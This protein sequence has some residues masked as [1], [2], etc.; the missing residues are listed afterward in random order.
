ML[1]DNVVAITGGAGLIGKSFSKAVIESGGKVIIGDISVEKGRELQEELG[2]KNVVFIEVDSSNV[3]SVD[4]FLKLGKENFGKIDS[5]IHCAY[6]RS[7]QW[8]TKF[9]DLEE[10]SLKQ[11]LFHQLGGAILFSQR[12]VSFYKKQ[13]YGNLIHISSIQGV[14][15]PKFEHYVHT[16]MVSPI[17]YSAIKSGIISITRYLAKYCKGQNIRVN[18]ISPGGILDNQPKIFLEKYNS[19]CASKG[20]MNPEDLNGTI[21]YLLSSYSQ[22]VNG[23]NIIIDDGWVL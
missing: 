5:A 4:N 12:L 6:P 22:Y 3:N 16:S 15:A 19:T 10:N 7:D 20:M 23:Q 1:K 17:E 21:L 14:S 2:D 18:C 8:G 11:D 9:E 13:G